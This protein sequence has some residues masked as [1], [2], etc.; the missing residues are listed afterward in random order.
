MTSEFKFWVSV[1]NGNWETV[2]EQIFYDS[3]YKYSNKLTPLIKDMLAGQMLA[4][5]NVR[6]RIEA[7]KRNA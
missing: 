4:Y 5:A 7:V 1:D 2:P 3:L 6:Y